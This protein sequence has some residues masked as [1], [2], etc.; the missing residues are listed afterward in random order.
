MGAFLT[1]VGGA[2]VANTANVEHYQLE[3][4]RT[5]PVNAGALPLGVYGPLQSTDTKP[6][7]IFDNKDFVLGNRA[8]E[9][10]FTA[11]ESNVIDIT[12]DVNGLPHR[13]AKESIC[14]YVNEV[15]YSKELEKNVRHKESDGTM[16][17]YFVPSRAMQPG[18]EVELLADYTR[19]YERIRERKGYG[20]KNQLGVEKSD[21]C[22]ASRL[23]RNFG[24]RARVERLWSDHMSAEQM[25]QAI[26]FV[27]EEMWVPLSR[28]AQSLKANHLKEHQWIG[29][30][31]LLWLRDVILETIDEHE[32]AAK[33]LPRQHY[34]ELLMSMDGTFLWDMLELKGGRAGVMP[35]EIRELILVEETCYRMH[36]EL[37]MWCHPFDPGLWCKI[38]SNLIAKLCIMSAMYFRFAGVP[39]EEND[40]HF[41]L[42]VYLDLT[43]RALEELEEGLDRIDSARGTK[44]KEAADESG[45]AFASGL[46]QDKLVT[47]RE[48]SDSFYLENHS[49]PKAVQAAYVDGLGRGGGKRK[50][51]AHAADNYLMF[52]QKGVVCAQEDLVEL[53]SVAR[54]SSSTHSDIN[55]L[56]YIVWQIGYPVHV[57]ATKYLRCGGQGFSAYRP[58]VLCDALGIDVRLLN[59]ATKKGIIRANGR[60]HLT[61]PVTS[62]PKAVKDSPFRIGFCSPNERR[63]AP[64]KRAVLPGTERALRLTRSRLPPPIPLPQAPGIAPRKSPS[65]LWHNRPSTIIRKP[66]KV[67]CVPER[68]T[69]GLP[70]KPST[71]VKLPE[72]EERSDRKKRTASS[73]RPESPAK[74]PRVVESSIESENES[75]LDTEE[76]DVA[77]GQKES[78]WHALGTLFRFD[79][80]MGSTK[81]A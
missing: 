56:W 22:R 8:S 37:L 43:R 64:K 9:Y 76:Q 57:F 14:T 19:V 73:Q 21:A 20:R 63:I 72:P 55:R 41:L 15:G 45:L 80:A 35:K 27:V 71:P 40:Q 39:P 10:A 74:C 59:F 58:E 77:D 24:E 32:E 17:Y 5:F 28:K 78:L 50:I 31:R 48:L 67:Q 44:R 75:S 18:D 36:D 60:S 65:T 25:E 54:R 11:S 12:D 38:A 4:K 49:C 61:I 13:A 6:A 1:F 47:I 66:T 70:P 79:S 23:R 2:K 33:Q 69:A 16:C 81:G 42:A 29:L 26:E 34:I 30:A 68:R 7:H 53:G 52:K 51:R 3:P 62:L 46:H